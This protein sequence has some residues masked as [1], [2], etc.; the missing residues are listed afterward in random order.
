M[1][2]CVMGKITPLR[3]EENMAE[4]IAV[5]LFAEDNAEK[6]LYLVFLINL[7]ELWLSLQ[8]ETAEQQ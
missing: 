4:I 1:F 7:M 8:K 6:S 2:Q 3:E 5:G